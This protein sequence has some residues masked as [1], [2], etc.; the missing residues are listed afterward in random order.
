MK[1]IGPLKILHKFGNNTYEFEIPLDLGISP[2]FNV[3][4]LFP[5][6]STHAHIDQ[7]SL[8]HIEG[9]DWIQDLPNCQY[10]Q[11][12]IIV[13]SKVIKKTRKGT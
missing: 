7:Y 9:L 12:D 8:T 3:C 1:K 6:K 13:D 4:D 2:I 5:Y 11:L 10:F